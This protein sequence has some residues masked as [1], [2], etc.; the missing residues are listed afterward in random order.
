MQMIPRKERSGTRNMEPRGSTGPTNQ[1]I[2]L[3][4]GNSL[5]FNEIN[6]RNFPSLRTPSYENGAKYRRISFDTDSRRGCCFPPLATIQRHPFPAEGSHCW[7]S[8]LHVDA[9][10]DACSR[11]RDGK[12]RKG[13]P[14]DAHFSGICAP[15][16]IGGCHR[17][18][19]PPTDPPSSSASPPI[20]FVIYRPLA[21]RSFTYRSP[22]PSDTRV[23]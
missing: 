22:P 7:P 20:F 5:S 15:Y 8:N 16:S 11:S 1:E 10:P 18:R 23:N 19:P 9:L 13:A 2:C 12:E 6:N 21:R 17:H 3:D 14:T 4:V